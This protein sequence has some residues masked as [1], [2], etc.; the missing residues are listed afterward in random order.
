[1]QSEFHSYKQGMKPLTLARSGFLDPKGSI[2]LNL[3]ELIGMIP[4]SDYFFTCTS[5]EEVAIKIFDRFDN[6]DF[7]LASIDFLV[8]NEAL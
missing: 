1:M 7:G 6:D 2:T 8:P 4:F 5:T 3:K